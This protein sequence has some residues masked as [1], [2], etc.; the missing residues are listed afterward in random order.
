MSSRS[1]RNSSVIRARIVV[2]RLPGEIVVEEIGGLDQLRLRVRAIRMQDA[3]LH[4]A[5]GCHED[6][7]HAPLRQAQEFQVPE[8][9]LAP[10]GRHHHA[11]ELRQLRQETGRRAHQLL[12]P[13]GDEFAFEPVDLAAIERLGHHQA[14]DEEAVTLGRRHAARGRMRAA[15]EAHL[16]QVRHHVADRRRRK[17]EAGVPRQRAR[18]DRLPVADVPLDQRL[19]EVLRAR[20]KHGNDFTALHRSEGRRSLPHL[21]FRSSVPRLRAVV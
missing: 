13:V 7:Q 17:L 6:E 19:E 20:F 21:H 15:D 5:F 2:E 11:G 4:V 18:T 10:L 12:R 16:L 3:V 1:V 9:R 14:V 8:R